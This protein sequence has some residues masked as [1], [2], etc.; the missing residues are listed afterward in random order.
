MTSLH[1]SEYEKAT[2]WALVA[3]PPPVTGLTVLTEKVVER[4]RRS[5]EVCCYDWSPKKLPRGW[6]FRA[7]RGWRVIRSMVKLLAAGRARNGRLYVAANSRDGLWLTMILSMLGRWLGHEVF[8]HHHSYL[9][10]DRFDRRMNL[11]CWW[12]GDRSV[13][14]VAC[15]QME[16][17]F[18]RR[19]PAAT[20]FVHVNPSLLTGPIGQSRAEP[21]KPFTLGHLGNLSRAKGIDIVLDTFRQIHRERGDVRLKLAGPFYPGEARR[22]VTA[23]RAALPGMVEWMG[24]VFGEEKWKFYRE[25][26]C[27]LFP[28][29]SESWGIVLNEAMASGVPVIAADRG[30]IRTVVGKRAGIVIHPNDDFAKRATDQ[31][32]RWISNPEEYRAASEAARQRAIDLQHEA[33][34]TLEQ[35][36][37]QVFGRPAA[38]LAAR[39]AAPA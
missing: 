3:L 33:D 8:L 4:L 14:V 7:V 29:R 18:H 38:Q 19:Y 28:T 25:I 2:I 30:C 37:D 24:P 21:R 39:Q 11:I 31:V 23:A 17:D 27:F 13:H 32:V 35:F 10:I 20:R 5:G 36:V 1:K 16:R 22:L 15:E 9:Y 26:D 34:E 6:R 12:L